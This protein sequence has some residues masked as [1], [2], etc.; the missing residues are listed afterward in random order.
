MAMNRYFTSILQATVLVHWFGETLNMCPGDIAR[1]RPTSVEEWMN[2]VPC[3]P[4]NRFS[5]LCSEVSDCDLLFNILNVCLSQ[6]SFYFNQS[7]T[8]EMKCSEKRICETNTACNVSDKIN[9]SCQVTTD[10]STITTEGNYVTMTSSKPWTPSIISRKTSIGLRT[11]SQTTNYYV[12]ELKSSTLLSITIEHTD[13]TT[14]VTNVSS[15]SLSTE[16]DHNVH[17]GSIISVFVVTLFVI[18]IVVLAVIG[19]NQK[20]VVSVRHIPRRQISTDSRA[21]MLNSENGCNILC[22]T[23]KRR[24]TSRVKTGHQST[25]ETSERQYTVVPLDE[26]PCIE[27][28]KKENV[29]KGCRET[30]LSVDEDEMC[31]TEKCEDHSKGVKELKTS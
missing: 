27:D 1:P 28:E 8:D 30:V 22:L 7:F 15:S 9:A 17:S 12:T 14:E 2:L 19:I 25:V 11:T 6:Y 21:P 16:L 26:P 29:E 18:V 4:P 31:T 10:S 5:L 13:N 24:M 3:P 23:L 20:C